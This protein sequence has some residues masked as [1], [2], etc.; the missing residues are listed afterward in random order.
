MRPQHQEYGPYRTWLSIIWPSFS[1]YGTFT[2][3][4]FGPFPKMEDFVI[5][6]A[7]KINF[8]HNFSKI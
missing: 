6:K 2:E 3:Y 8:I 7:K 4:G 5:F 1:E